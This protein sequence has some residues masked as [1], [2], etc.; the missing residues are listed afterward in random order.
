M[1]VLERNGFEVILAKQGCCGLPLLSNGAFKDARGSALVSND[2]TRGPLKN[3]RE[4][5][6]DDLDPTVVPRLR[7]P[8][9]VRSQHG[10]PVP[11]AHQPSGQV[12]DERTG[13]VPLESGVGLGQEEEVEAGAARHSSH[14]L[15]E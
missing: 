3:G 10:H 6:W 12:A 5:D 14:S 13:G 11:P 9:G 7:Q 1:E 15:I 4:M 8:L 2:M